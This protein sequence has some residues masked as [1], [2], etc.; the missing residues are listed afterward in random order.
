[1]VFLQSLRHRHRPGGP[2]LQDLRREGDRDGAGEPVPARTDIW[3]VGFQTADELALKLGAAARLAVPGAG[4]G[5]ARPAGGERR[6]ATSAS[7]RTL[8]SRPPT[9]LTQIAAGRHPRRGRAAADHRRDRPRQRRPAGERS[10]AGGTTASEA[11]GVPLGRRRHPALPQAAVPGRTRRR[12]AGAG[13]RRR[14][15]TRCRRS[16][17][18]AAVGVGRAEDGD[19]VRR[20]PA[21]RRSAAAV[22]QKLLVVTGGPGTGKTT[23]VR[24]DPRDLPGE[25]AARAA[26]RPDRPGRQAAHR[27]DRPRGEDDPPPAGVRPRPRRLPPRTRRTRSTSTC[28]SSTRRRWSTWC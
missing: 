9:E 18:D 27:V 22:T 11:A 12:P 24:G 8:A 16:N 6:T 2:H 10:D 25:G 5:A 26:L 7:R 15:R 28:S 13:A 19:R 23:I 21:R 3:G 17:V 20:Q 4:G 14:G 1:M